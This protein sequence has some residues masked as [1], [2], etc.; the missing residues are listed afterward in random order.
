MA[1]ETLRRCSGARI[2]FEATTPAGYP[3]Q[4]VEV[5]ALA[6]RYRQRAWERA[7]TFTSLI[8]P[9][10][11][12]PVIAHKVERQTVLPFAP[13]HGPSPVVY[14]HLPSTSQTPERHLAGALVHGPSPFE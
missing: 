6:V 1:S 11:F 12:A 13:V 4:P 2:N 14:P 7:G 8:K 3:A 10:A 9:P 5:A